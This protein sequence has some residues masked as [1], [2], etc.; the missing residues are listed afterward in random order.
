MKRV[1]FKTVGCRLNQAE[2]A[3]MAAGFEA[4]GYAVVP[5]G[6]DCD[7]CVIHTC[8]IT[9]RAEQKCLMFARAA[10]RRPNP[11]VVVLAGCAV[12]VAGAA[13]KDRC[14]A[15]LLAG[16]DA[17]F[18]I[19]SLLR[20]ETG[21]GCQV[22]GVRG[23]V[24]SV[25]CRVSEGVHESA[26]PPTSGIRHP[27]S[28]VRQPG[29]CLLTPDSFLLPRFD[30][31]RALVKVQD[32]CDFRC[33]YCIV[34]AARGAP[35]SRPLAEVVDEV[36]RLADAGYREVTLT[37]ANLGCYEDGTRRLVDL[38]ASI[39]RLPA[40][41][42]IRL[43]S[44]ESSTTERAIIDCMASSAK[45]CRYLHVPL[46]S[47]DDR[48]LQAMGRRYTARQY[49]DTVAYALERVPLVGLGTDVLVGLPG[50]D[51]PAFANTVAIVNDLPFSN[52]HIFPYSRRPG[53]RAAG[54]AGQVSGAARKERCSRLSEIGRRKR[55]E[56][57][58][59]FL[60][61]PV[62]VLIE[63]VTCQGTG[64]GWTSER[65]EGRV[66]GNGLRANQIVAF[67]PRHLNGDALCG[68]PTT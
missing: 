34:P 3:R 46:Q 22:S 6:S 14:G 32:G 67:T 53:T 2:T 26:Q 8:T 47:G 20:Q 45:L 28:G 62:A 11:P 18:D 16:R 51:E 48:V 12:D 29:S 27:A 7:V 30:T 59:R 4:A 33:A 5:Y 60:G 65:L 15:D 1:A 42:R 21:V 40:I 23:R 36:R 50:E 10:R 61:R 39:E 58:A 13:L 43:S 52:L 17:K 37:G 35:R 63:N 49:R 54:M 56:F 31:T 19:P 64:T 68:S 9:G 66:T 25:E 38:I 55:A 24:S 41:E 57:A 44:I